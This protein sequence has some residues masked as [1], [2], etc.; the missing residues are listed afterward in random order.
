MAEGEINIPTD[1]DVV[2]YH[3]AGVVPR[4]DGVLGFRE[5]DDLLVRDHPRLRRIFVRSAH[6]GPPMSMVLHWSDGTDLD[7]LDR[8]LAAGGSGTEQIKSAVA[9]DIAYHYC[10]QCENRWRVVA[11]S[12]PVTYSIGISPDDVVRH[13]YHERCPACGAP[14][15]RPIVE[16][17]APAPLPEQLK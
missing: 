12:T 17:L 2:R 7:A 3:V 14:T 4:G 8:R 11:L 13:V 9:G 15:R 16:F 5:E 10:A 1:R 6:H